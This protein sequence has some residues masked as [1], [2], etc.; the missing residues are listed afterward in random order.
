MVFE[1]RGVKMHYEL[2]GEGKPLLL[3]HGWGGNADSFLPL[4]RDFEGRRQIIAL[5][6]PGHGQSDEPD[7]PWSVDEYAAYI[8]NFLGELRVEGADIV[9]HSFGGRVAILLAAEWPRLVGKM[10]LTGA[11]GIPPRPSGKKTA[12]ARLYTALR[13]VASSGAVGAILGEEGQANLREKLVQRFGSADYRAL[14]P[15]MRQTFNRVIHQDLTPSLSKIKAPTLLVWGRDDTETPLWMGQ[16]MER[17]IPDA[18]LVAWEGC[19][20]FAYLDRYADFR[21]VTEAFLL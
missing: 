7:C 20:H 15:S 6:F 18:G 1:R 17:L 14:T 21:R 8:A 3:L 19:G 5:D 2:L 9:A 12:R 10:I 16:T 13:S 4:I 11:A